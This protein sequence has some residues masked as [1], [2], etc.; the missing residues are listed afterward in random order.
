MGKKRR[1]ERGRKRRNAE[2]YFLFTIY[3]TSNG[4][5]DYYSREGTALGKGMAVGYVLLNPP[6]P[7]GSTTGCERGIRAKAKFTVQG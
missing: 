4:N 3:E 5:C 2:T 7:V 1:R 6:F